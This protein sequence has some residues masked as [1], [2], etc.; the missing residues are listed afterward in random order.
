MTLDEARMSGAMKAA[1]PRSAVPWW[2][3]R[4]PTRESIVVAALLALIF[5]TTYLIAYFLRGELLFRPSDA[6]AIVGTIGYVVILKLLVFYV[7]GLCHRPWRAARF[8]DLNNLLRASTTAL[9]ILVA[10]N[11]FGQF[12]LSDRIVIPRSVLLLD[13]AFTVLG[14]GGMQAIARSIY[15]ELVP[16]SP[17]GK[18]VVLIIDASDESRALAE[19]LS[20]NC[21]V[22]GFLDD[23]PAHYGVT[24]GKAR[25]LGPVDKAAACAERLRATDVFVRE[26]TVFGAQLQELCDACA[27]INVRV[28]IA[29]SASR[30]MLA[31][32]E[33]TPRGKGHG[34]R[35]RDV[36]LRDLLSRPQAHLV[37]DD[38]LVAPFI[39]GKT[40]LVTGAGGSV[41]SEIC[42]QAM[43]FGPDSLVMVE[44]SEL[45]LFSIHRELSSGFP[46]K[47]AR[48]VSVLGDASNADRMDRLLAEHKPHVI[49]HAAAFKH[50]PLLE[51][52]PVEAIENNTLAC[53]SLAELADAHGVETFVALSTDKAVQPTSVMGASKLIAERFLQAFG[54]T[55][56]NRVVIIRFG[57]VLGSSGSAVPIFQEQLALGLPITVTHPDVRRHFMTGD[58]AAQLV[59][60]AAAIEGRG[61]TYVLDM[62]PPLRIVDLVYSL[63]FLM[64]IPRAEVTIDFCGLRPGEK[65]DEGLFFE[66]EERQPTENPLVTRVRRVPRRLD[67]VRSWLAELKEASG[68]DASR[69]ASVLSSIVADD[70]AV[71]QSSLVAMPPDAGRRVFEPVAVRSM[72]TQPSLEE[73]A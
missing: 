45:A 33:V 35:V 60:Y 15:E 25:V 69:A 73:G 56:K 54:N 12:I 34:F 20:T 62:G 14:V 70:N 19:D 32:S 22:A 2:K 18:L 17:V 64:H 44:Q 36:E 47:H 13:C 52:H 1:I 51:S 21:F 8:A 5:H 49:I 68:T 4:M 27:L 42:R 6:K 65:L 26:G 58:E 63:A 41:G 16:A 67:L 23:N 66:D 59:L 43:R 7:R 46:D 3:T 39:R 72:A 71:E 48:L 55:V 38:P 57:N 9:L 31:G 50:V 30:S 10:Y 61:G 53:A 11:Y 37:D 28:N 40:V 24:V 29:G